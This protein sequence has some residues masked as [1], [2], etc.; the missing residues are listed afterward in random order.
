MDLF[1]E[2]VIREWYSENILNGN[3]YLYLRN[4]YIFHAN[5]PLSTRQIE[6][7]IAN[8]SVHYIQLPLSHQRLQQCVERDKHNANINRAIPSKGSMITRE[9]GTNRVPISRYCYSSTDIILPNGSGALLLECND[10]LPGFLCVSRRNFDPM[11]TIYIRETVVRI[12][13]AR[14]SVHRLR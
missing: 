12:F 14:V 4:F 13:E 7:L 6:W 5:L 2:W 1:S 9:T 11:I 10:H 3:R 8:S